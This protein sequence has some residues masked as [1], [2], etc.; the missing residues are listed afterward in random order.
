MNSSTIRK[1]ILAFALAATLHSPLYAQYE[2]GFGVNGSDLEADSAIEGAT[3]T[4]NLNELYQGNGV[5]NAEPAGINNFPAQDSNFESTNA[6]SENKSSV[7][8]ANTTDNYINAE[9]N[10][11]KDTSAPPVYDEPAAKNVA[12][13]INSAPTSGANFT[14]PASVAAPV[15]NGATLMNQINQPAPA[16]LAAPAL[17]ATG[18][19]AALQMPAEAPAAT[20]PQAILPTATKPTG[21]LTTVV[22]TEPETVPLA[23]T[24]PPPNEFSGAPPIPGTLQQVAD[25]EA[26]EDYFVQSG[27]TLYDIC[28][29]LLDEG[30]Y[31][32]KLWSMNPEI[33]NPHFIFPNMKL[34]FYP[35]DSENPPY[36]Q[37]VSEDDV[38]P[39]D[40][41]DL[42]EEQL[43]KEPVQLQI[44][45]PVDEVAVEQVI[46]VIGPEQ[47]TDTDALNDFYLSGG[48]RYA[49][50]EEKVQVP[51]FIF[52]EEKEPLAFVVSG[53]EGEISAG[54]GFRILL[55]VESG[56]STGT[57]YSIIRPG[58]DLDNPETGDFVGYQYFF[59]ANVRVEKNVDDDIYVGLVQDTRLS[60]RPNDMIV[61]YISTYRSIPTNEAV[62]S[63]SSAKANI[64]GFEYEDQ[65]IG[66]AGHYAFIDKGTSAGVS[67]GMY[68]QVFSTP[69]FYSATFGDSKLPVDYRPVGV[70]RIIDSTDAGA[71]GYIVRNN[72]E[73]RVGDR[74]GSG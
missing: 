7:P 53:R 18:A 9:D 1:N 26:P 4:D 74:A 45:R 37:V 65:L 29:Q 16:P 22:A 34:R 52:A 3:P 54:P 24:L 40:K 19:P 66:A 23:P 25:G 58:K 32:P 35:G 28:D 17:G 36:L 8:A 6:A 14:S 27:D 73:M 55:E 42:D 59:I 44:P 68:L 13:P 15:N 57:I 62:G 38:M 31:W 12:T 60:V 48:R 2:G 5:G 21:P 49:G 63:F 20:G 51:G 67:P 56:V 46:Q 71:V 43:I 11:F 70:M 39:I 61:N 72:S 50:G 47:V 30:G 41:G 69:G 33:K 64:V 10:L